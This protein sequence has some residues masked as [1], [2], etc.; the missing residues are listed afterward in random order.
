MIEQLSNYDDELADLYLSGEINEITTQSI[1]N[2]IRKAV[3]SKRAVPLL[4]GSALKN[5]GVQPLLDA[6]LKY[7]PSPEHIQA[8]GVNTT[9]GEPVIRD[10]SKKGKLCA[11]AFKVVNDKDKGLITFFRVYSGLLKNRAKLRNSNLNEV[12]RVSGLLRVRAD[13]T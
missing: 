9:T 5:K 8:T 13:E 12:E 2:A 11:L 7:L 3:L 1:D 10:P 4:C 6:V